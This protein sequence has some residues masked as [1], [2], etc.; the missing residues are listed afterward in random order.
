MARVIVVGAGPAGASL[1]LLLAGRGVETLLVERQSD[2]AREFR[3]EVLLPSG[4]DAL[5][6][7]GVAGLLEA[8]P[9]HRPDSV[10]LYLNR[11]V[12]FSFRI[13]DVDLGG[14]DPLAV[15]QPALL[16]ALVAEAA[17][18]PAFAFL[19]GAS[20]RDLLR[21]PDGR[22]RGVRVA[23]AEGER[24]LAADLVI[25]ADGRASAV[26]RRGNFS[27]RENA[28][29]MDVVWCK[30]PALP[31]LRGAR[32]YLGRGHLLI[33]YHTWGEQLQI[34]WGILKGSF[35]ELR[36][37]GVAEWLGEMAAHV[38]DDLA[39]HLRAHAGALTH[40]FLLDAVS[41]RVTRWSAPGVLLIGDAAH[42]SSPVGGQGLNLALRDA[43]VAANHLV[44]ALRAGAGPAALDAAAARA[45]AERLP[46]IAAV[47]RAQALPPRIILSRAWWGEP[48]RRALALLVQSPLGRRGAGAQ[49]RL[50]AFGTTDVKL[51]V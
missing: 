16:E 24:E 38:S 12:L 10:T 13:G 27:A 6:Q 47:Q 36:R 11:R 20:V 33:A 8:I 41:D 23:G 15:S 43:I 44:P 51:A 4:V 28:P 2:F 30:L 39:A 29:P 32:A 48:A 42:T 22:V 49:A 31:G 25:G 18:R 21:A 40:P 7:M 14:F 17:K 37:H 46:E 45:E 19:R 1:A 26:R 35:G 9:H 3:G 34:A 50:F 5:H